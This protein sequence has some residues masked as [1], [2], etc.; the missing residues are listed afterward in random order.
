MK[1]QAGVVA[2]ALSAVSA[3]QQGTQTSEVAP[4]LSYSECTSSGCE[5]KSGSV[6]I[7]SNWRWIHK[8]GTTT[9]CYTGNKWDATICPDAATC[10]KN[11]VVE[12][13]GAEYEN[14]YGV[15]AS[16]SKLQLDFVT[17]GQYSK[18]IGSRTYLKSSDDSYKM[19]KL[20]NKEFTYTVDDSNLDCGLNGAL[21]F[22]SMDADGGASKYGNAGAKMGLGYCDAQ[23]P[24]DI[25]FINGEANMGS[26]KPSETDPNSGT[27]KYGSCCTEIDIWEANKVAT[28]FTMHACSESEQTRCSGTDCGDN[29]SDRYKGVCDKNGC[30]M[31]SYRLGNKGFFGPGSNFEVDSS[32]PVQVTTQFITSDGTDSGTLTEVK[33]FYTQNG[34][35]I[36][37]SQY[38]VNGNQHSSI[39]DD[40]C[41]DWVATTQD[42]TNFAAKGGLSAIGDALE[43]GV[44][45]VMSLW[46]DHYANMLW[47]DSTY[48]VDSSEPGAA[49]GSCSTSSGVPA[50]VESSQA[51]AHVIFSDIKYGPLGST[52]DGPSPTP[53]PSPSPTPSPSPSPSNCP[54]GSLSN[55]IDLCPVDAFT[56]CVESCQRRCASALV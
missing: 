44:V 27:G 50:T 11:C 19:F 53:S 4:S 28:A 21:Y 34:K 38:N 7:D 16:G 32:K 35:T 55:C 20:K 54:G 15:K 47:L 56:A 22:V 39:T 12:G 6:V 37:H 41:D 23:C 42:G 43:T 46:D 36:E 17:N 18:N 51:S 49:R 3:Q 24:H 29:G 48:P 52:T 8:T 30:D 2:C 1:F 14:T 13:A 45:L 9:N 5:S 40:Y 26:W 10:S 33:Q 31:Q 25:K